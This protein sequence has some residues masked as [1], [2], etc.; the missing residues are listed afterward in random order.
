MDRQGDVFAKTT[1]CG[2]KPV[3][4]ANDLA[5]DPYGGFYFTD[6]GPPVS[7]EKPVGRICHSDAA[8]N[9]RLVADKL[10]FPNG[11]V[12]RPDGR[13]LL[14]SLSGASQIVEFPVVEPGVAGEM[15][16]LVGLD[17]DGVDGLALDAEGNLYFAASGPDGGYVGV[18]GLDGELK[19]AYRIPMADV[20]NLVFGGS[21]S[22]QLW[23][24]GRFHPIDASKPISPQMGPDTGK[25]GLVY[26]LNIGPAA[27]VSTPPST[28]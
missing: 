20:S 24:T 8:G 11:V 10:P 23:I 17:G 19:N 21:N 14:V 9:T 18:V 22:E 5:I 27:G 1:A 2:S 12:L 13:T 15:K 3:R 28:Q 4:L 7:F 16:I 26:R 6:P 25:F